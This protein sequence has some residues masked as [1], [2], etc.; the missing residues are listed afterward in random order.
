[1]NPSSSV[2]MSRRLTAT[3]NR[4]A[5]LIKWI[6]VAA[7]VLSVMLIFRKLPVGPA[8][9]ALL[10][11][12]G[13]LGLWG[14][15][16]FGLIYIVAVVALAPGSALTLAAGTL[17]GL[18]VGTITVSVASTTAAALAFLIARYLARDKVLK[19]VKKDPRFDAIDKAISESDWKIIALLRLSPAVP[20]N[21]QNYLY[22]LTGARFWPAMLTSW[23]TM[24]P[25][26][27]LYVYLGHV[28]RA[29]LEAASGGQRHRT[30]GEWAMIVVGLLAT[31]AVTVYVTRLARKALKERT[32]IAETGKPTPDHTQSE[33]SSASSGPKGWPWGATIT[34]AVA[35]A[36]LV[37]AVSVQLKPELLRRVFGGLLGPPRVTLREAYATKPDGPAFDHSA[38]DKLVKAHVAPGGWVDYEGL[39]KDAEHLD[40]YL[41][42]LADA[43]FDDLG[44]DQKLALLLNAYNAFTLRLILDYYPVDSIRSIP[45]EKRWDAKRWQIGGYTWGLNQIEHEQIRPKFR[46]PR[47]HFAL[48]CAAIGCPPL[49]SEAYTADRLEEQLEDQARYVHGHK[50]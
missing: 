12:I 33:A 40:S 37:A 30:P 20:F 1:M 31:V 48:V 2:T 32:A 29:G 42:S 36:M 13:R 10:G 18:V 38:Y 24:L 19:M 3:A 23:I 44:R 15:V 47:V 17:L 16:V 5:A 21:L 50:R 9:E 8:I 41:R 46:E 49:R 35:L 39:K 45:A 14:P 4:N 22:G 43:L 11:W 25:G 6:S 26:T 7:I 34:A 27:F 28:G